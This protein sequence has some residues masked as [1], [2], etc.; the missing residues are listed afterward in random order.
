MD[1]HNAMK[2][3]P[4]NRADTEELQAHENRYQRHSRRAIQSMYDFAVWRV[5]QLEHQRGVLRYLGEAGG[6][7]DELFSLANRI[8]KVEHNHERFEALEQELLYELMRRSDEE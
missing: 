6:E 8:E 7:L 1:E 4:K 3:F 5:M 2:M